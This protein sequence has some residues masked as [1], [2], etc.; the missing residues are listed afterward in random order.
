MSVTCMCSPH[1]E[2]TCV[3]AAALVPVFAVLD[4]ELG[5]ASGRG[6][7]PG[8]AFQCAITVAARQVSA[9]LSGR[10]LAWLRAFAGGIANAMAQSASGDSMECGGGASA[11]AAAP[12][13]AESAGEA[14]MAAGG[15]PAGSKARAGSS[16]VAGKGSGGASAGS[17]AAGS[18]AVADSSPGA[19]TGGSGG[20]GGGGAG[21]R[22]LAA[23]AAGAM[24][25][26][27]L[28]LTLNVIRSPQL[29]SHSTWQTSNLDC[30]CCVVATGGPHVGLHH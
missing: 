27:G 3:Q 12:T 4:P 30:N 22:G 29:S 9:A 13:A 24:G 28:S 18:S 20:G 16:Q 26:V 11:S 2:P 7:A 8:P 10:Q 25:T 6:A 14:A 23:L 17:M 19:G 1:D 15:V 21:G 5:G